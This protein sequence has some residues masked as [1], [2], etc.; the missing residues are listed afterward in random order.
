MRF[1][2]A[3][4]SA[5]TSSGSA[6]RAWRTRRTCPTPTFLAEEIADDLRSALEQI[7]SV[8]GDL[9]ARAAANGGKDG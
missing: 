1:W 8:L 7:E 6:T 4:R 9:N 3:T 5:S 2:P